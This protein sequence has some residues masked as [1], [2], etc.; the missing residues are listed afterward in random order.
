MA[1]LY[2]AVMGGPID[3]STCA[4]ESAGVG[5]SRQVLH[6]AR[7]TVIR[8][9]YQP[10]AIFQ[11]HQHPEEQTTVVLS[12]RITFWLGGAEATLGPGESL[13]VPPD[14][15]HGARVEGDQVVETINVLAPHRA[16]APPA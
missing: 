5:V 14:A 4:V 7:S 6:G 15:P 1:A 12:G 16:Q 11:T 8:Y 3:W 13:V 9:V 2:C 10:G